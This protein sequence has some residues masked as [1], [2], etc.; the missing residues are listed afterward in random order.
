MSA[1]HDKE[2]RATE[3]LLAGFDRPGRSPRAP[4]V[5]GAI[6]FHSQAAPPGTE[7]VLV[8]RRQPRALW[9]WL[10]V[11]FVL[12]AVIGVVGFVAAM[13]PSDG[14]AGLD[15]E[16]HAV[17]TPIEPVVPAS[18]TVLAAPASATPASSPPPRAPASTRKPEHRD[19]F[20]R[21]L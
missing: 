10:A 4:A 21:E 1:P 3:D 16:K 13:K 17:T 5:R 11:A 6:D 14:P 2:R 19:D 15:R 7:T 12:S 18:V 20:A 8:T 9:P